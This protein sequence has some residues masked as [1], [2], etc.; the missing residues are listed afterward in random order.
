MAVQRPP[1][2]WRGDPGRR[3]IREFTPIALTTFAATVLLGSVR[4]WQELGRIGDLWTTHYGW[5]LTGKVVLVAITLPCRCRP[6]AVTG[7]TPGPR[8]SS[9]SAW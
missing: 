6:G 9:R 1:G 4:G 5:L 3:L 7:P 8:A 2:T